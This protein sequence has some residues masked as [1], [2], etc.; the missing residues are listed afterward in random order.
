MKIRQRFFIGLL[1]LILVLLGINYF[2]RPFEKYF[3]VKE[4]VIKQ[5]EQAE[6]VSLTR[7]DILDRLSTEEKVSQMIAHPIVIDDSQAATPSSNISETGF[8]T[9]FGSKISSASAKQKI[10]EIESFYRD[11]LLSPKFAVDHEGGR[12][13]RLSGEGYTL[14][15]SWKEV[16]ELEDSVE[17]KKLLKTSAKELRDTGIDIVL[18]PVL[19]VGDNQILKDRVCSDSYAV[20]ADR[21]VEYALAFNDFGILPVLKHFPGIGSITKDLHND[22]AF[23]QVIDNDSKLYKYVIEESLRVGVMISHAGILNQD[24][25]IPCSL[26][27]DCVSELKNAYP[28]IIIFSD[29]LDMKAASFNK[30][31]TDEE[32]NLTQI[33][34]EA[35]IAGNEVLIYGQSVSAEEIKKIILSLS[36]KYEKDVNFSE[37]VDKAVLKVIDYKY[38]GRQI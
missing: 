23:V 11:N 29:A 37:L 9:I 38:T 4:E 8:I 20:V 24:P 13:Q 15:P 3:D 16:C 14:L 12:V 22:F 36:A 25:G 26:S 6:P 7:Q 21:G 17:L 18:A 5:E 32:K 34:A 27:K 33:S 2:I 35:V 30:D 1:F 31:K 19:D 28:Q 10:T